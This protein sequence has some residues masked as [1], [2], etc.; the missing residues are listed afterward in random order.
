MWL[1][2]IKSLLSALGSLLMSLMTEKFMKK[3]I[4]WSLEWIVTKTENTRDDQLLRLVKR[5][6]DESEGK[7]WEDNDKNSTDKQKD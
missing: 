5:A 6:W 3:L 7:A 1:T 2:L 4:V